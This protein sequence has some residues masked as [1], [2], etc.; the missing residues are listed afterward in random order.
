MTS[1]K[2]ARNSKHIP[3]RSLSKT[4][5]IPIPRLSLVPAFF[6]PLPYLTPLLFSQY[7]LSP[8]LLRLRH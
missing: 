8:L 3:V 2:S 5:K 6:P 4:S 1:S 7:P